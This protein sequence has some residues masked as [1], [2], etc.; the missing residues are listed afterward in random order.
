MYFEICMLN[1]FFQVVAVLYGQKVIANFK[2]SFSFPKLENPCKA[3]MVA[4]IAK[5]LQFSDSAP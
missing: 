4:N 3:K 5:P 1:D 2:E